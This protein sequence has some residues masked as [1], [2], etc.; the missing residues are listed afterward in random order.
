MVIPN[1]SLIINTLNERYDCSLKPFR[2]K[3]I[4]YEGIVGKE[5]LIVCTPS[6]KIHVRG[7]GW[8]DLTIKQAEI[9]DGADIAILAIRLPNKVYFLD[10]KELRKLMKDK[11]IHQNLKEGEHWKFYVWNDFIEVRGTSEKLLVQ[12]IQVSA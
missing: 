3:Q 12:P 8:F 10:Y 11:A 5:R 7:H 4:I 1:K 2:G 6:S 9:L